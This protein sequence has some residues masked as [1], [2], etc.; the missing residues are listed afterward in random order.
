MIFARG[1]TKSLLA[2]NKISNN[3][4]V[5]KAKKRLKKEKEKKTKCRFH[6]KIVDRENGKIVN[7]RETKKGR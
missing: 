5:A 6:A 4:L 2:A 1:I 3:I 7:Q